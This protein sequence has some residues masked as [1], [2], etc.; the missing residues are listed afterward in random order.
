MKPRLTILGSGTCVPCLDRS[1]CSVLVE[2]GASQILL[3][4]GPGTIRRLLE[5]GK[6]PDGVT[7]ILLSHFHPDHCADL[8]PFLFA[9]KY[10]G[11]RRR[12]PAQVFAGPGF[13]SFFAALQNAYGNWLAGPRQPWSIHELDPDQGPVNELDFTLCFAPVHHRPESL[14][15]RIETR[16]GFCLVYGGDTGYCQSLV[17]LAGRADLLICEASMPNNLKIEGHLTPALAGRVATS[18]AVGK[19]IL[20]HFYPACDAVD[21]AKQCRA[22]YK[23]PLVL[24]KDLLTVDLNP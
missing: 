17:E 19:L 9:T 12:Q 2:T 1:S 20:T 8:V 5:A 22:T 7:H 23:G 15:F 21:I 4:M 11:S 6:H 3:D 18:A 16:D 14:A 13:E 10:G 24:A